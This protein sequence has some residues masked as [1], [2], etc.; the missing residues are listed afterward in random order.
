MLISIAVP[1]G[2]MNVSNGRLRSA[3]DLGDGYTQFNWFVS[4][5]IN[6]Y[7]VSLNVADYVHFDDQY[8]GE[9]GNL[10]LDYYVLRENLEKAKKQFGAN[11]KPMFCL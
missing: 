8:Q 5:P 2:L 6:N 9:N 3:K 10:T 4:Y 1:K 11:V 7:N